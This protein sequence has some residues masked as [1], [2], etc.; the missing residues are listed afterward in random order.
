MP[1]LN[2]WRFHY[3]TIWKRYIS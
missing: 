2:N 1:N 3:I